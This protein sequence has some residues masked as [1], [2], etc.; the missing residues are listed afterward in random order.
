MWKKQASTQPAEE[1]PTDC[2]PPRLEFQGFEKVASYFEGGRFGTDGGALPLR[3]ADLLFGLT[4]RATSD[5]KNAPSEAA[6]C[7]A[8][9]R[10]F[11]GLQGHD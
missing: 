3:Q 11:V 6:G 4:P 7:A 8:A 10:P 9:V 5:V 2:K 1:N